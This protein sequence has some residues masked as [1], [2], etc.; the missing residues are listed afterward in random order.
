VCIDVCDTKQVFFHRETVGTSAAT[1]A[2]VLTARAT[3]KRLPQ[4]THE[5]ERATAAAPTR[6]GRSLAQRPGLE[7]QLEREAIK[8]EFGCASVDSHK[9]A[10][11]YR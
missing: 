4:T 6:C 8:E 10:Q 9:V 2:L 11:T 7:P 3:A 5:G 1:S